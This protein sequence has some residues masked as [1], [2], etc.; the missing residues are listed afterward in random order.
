MEKEEKE[1]TAA[2]PAKAMF[3]VKWIVVGILALAL[4]GG[5]AFFALYYVLQSKSSSSQEN[6]ATE[7]KADKADKE[8]ETEVG[9][10]CPMEPFIVNLLDKGGKRYLKVKMELEVPNEGVSAELIRRKSQL[11]DTILLL[12]TSKKFED[13]KQLDGKFQLRN[14]LIFRINQVLQTGKVQALY[15][16]EFVVQ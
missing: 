3:P 10:M 6:I 1:N 13:V 7:T 15:F 12:L 9:M 16:T 5:G 14:E 2:A 8:K 11:R 4:M